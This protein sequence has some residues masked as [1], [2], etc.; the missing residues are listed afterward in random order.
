MLNL[1][2]DS[3]NVSIK[4]HRIPQAKILTALYVRKND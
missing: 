1:V 2:W 4:P 3:K